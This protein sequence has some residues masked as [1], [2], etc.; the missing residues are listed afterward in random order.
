[1][2]AFG[3]SLWALTRGPHYIEKNSTTNRSEGLDPNWIWYPCVME[4]GLAGTGNSSAVV[5]AAAAPA[6]VAPRGRGGGRSVFS[7]K[8][9]AGGSL[10]A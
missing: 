1:M 2:D 4:W 8:K 10:L 3:E 5:V 6:V 7:G 9:A